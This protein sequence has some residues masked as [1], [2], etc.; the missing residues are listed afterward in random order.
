MDLDHY[1]TPPHPLTP[2]PTNSLTQPPRIP[3]HDE[4]WHKPLFPLNMSDYLGFG[5]SCIGL[6][7]AAG[8]GIGGGGILVPLYVLVLNFTPKVLYTHLGRWVGRLVS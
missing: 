6:M 2:S 8:G 3:Q 7:I 4:H 1:T 5:L